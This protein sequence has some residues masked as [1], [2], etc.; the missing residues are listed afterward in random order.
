[1]NGKKMRKDRVTAGFILSKNGG[2]V[3]S[4]LFTIFPLQY[5]LW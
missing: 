1:M 4:P 3:T 5:Y 2:K